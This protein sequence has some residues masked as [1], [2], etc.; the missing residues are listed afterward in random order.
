MQKRKRQSRTERQR[1]EGK[2]LIIEVVKDGLYLSLNR[3]GKAELMEYRYEGVNELGQHVFDK[4]DDA[5]L[6]DLFEDWKCNGKFE[7]ST[8]P[9]GLS[10]ATSIR[11]PIC[12]SYSDSIEAKKLVNQPTTVYSDL[13][14]DA[15]PM[16][17]HIWYHANYMTESILDVI[18]RNK[19]VFFTYLGGE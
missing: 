7:Y 6:W 17:Y 8:E 1:F 4:S 2:C 16:E 13:W 14:D 3:A 5:I 10:E 18:Y 19:R 15:A 11:L 9:L 12:T